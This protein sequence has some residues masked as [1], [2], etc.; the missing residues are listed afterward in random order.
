MLMEIAELC[1]EVSALNQ[2]AKRDD[3][4][5]DCKFMMHIGTTVNS[6]FEAVELRLVPKT[7]VQLPLAAEK[8]Y[9]KPST[10]DTAVVNTQISTSKEKQKTMP[11][12]QPSSALARV[13]I[14]SLSSGRSKKRMRDLNKK[15]PENEVRVPE[16]WS[17]VLM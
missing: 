10:Q 11:N 13:E 14:R 12:A 9:F 3:S 17:T 1:K 5:R 2:E 7:M 15:P 16:N 8:N 6:R 4:E